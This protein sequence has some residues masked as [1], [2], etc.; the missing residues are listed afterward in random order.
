MKG[1]RVVK[2]LLISFI[3]PFV[4]FT[5]WMGGSALNGYIEDGKY[6]FDDRGR[7]LEVAWYDF[8]LST[9]LGLGTIVSLPI[10]GVIG[11]F[12]SISRKE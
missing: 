3:A 7:N 4:L 6:F 9:F 2:F 1:G 11:F 5:V 12:N 8:Y 10:I